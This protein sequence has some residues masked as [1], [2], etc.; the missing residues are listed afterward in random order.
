MKRSFISVGVTTGFC[1]C[2]LLLG[3][4]ASSTPSRHYV[5]SPIADQS[6]ASSE[7]SCPSVGIGPIKLPE[8]VNRMQIVTR[9][10]PNELTLSYSNLWAE[11][12]ADSVP[13]TL[14]ENI[15]RLICTKEILFFPWRPSKVPDVRVEVELLQLDGA[16][17]RNV[18]IEAWWRV[19]G[20]T[21]SKA[22]IIRNKTY[23]EPVA[24]QNYEALVQAHSS[25]LAA[26]SRDIAGALKEIKSAGVSTTTK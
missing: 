18:T 24:G 5:L 15:S 4:C 26:L 7:E 16:L 22:G 6:K 17:G 9:T 23:N 14:A 2:L 13:R 10:S 11:P 12:L 8:Y 3:G 19:I 25:A 1:L 21:D 20:R